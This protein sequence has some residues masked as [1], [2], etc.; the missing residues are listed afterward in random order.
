MGTKL[1]E[2][3]MK[4]NEQMRPKGRYLAGHAGCPSAVT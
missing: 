4:L 3:R 2:W 1:P